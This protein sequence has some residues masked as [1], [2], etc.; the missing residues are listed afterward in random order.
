MKNVV[1]RVFS[2][3][4]M[5]VTLL[6]VLIG[7][8]NRLSAPEG[9]GLLGYKGYIVTSNSMQPTF[10][11]GD[12]LVVKKTPYAELNR[13]DVIT[14]LDGDTIV[15]HRISEK[16]EE[17]IQTKGDANEEAD[18]Y[19]VQERNYIGKMKYIFAGLG[20]FLLFFQHPSFFSIL[21][22]LVGASILYLFYKEGEEEE[23][24]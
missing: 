16:T 18:L 10:S 2:F 11:A 13:K 17:G 4:F 22:F 19:Q 21:L 12:Y 6:F 7:I 1:K 23:K 9:T 20:S 14:F 24:I 8:M 5:L 15:T 3:L